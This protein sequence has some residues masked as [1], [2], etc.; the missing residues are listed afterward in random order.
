[1]GLAARQAGPLW[2]ERKLVL[3]LGELTEFQD[4]YP[5]SSCQLFPMQTFKGMRGG[6][7]L[8]L[9]K[10]PSQTVCLVQSDAGREFKGSRVQLR[11]VKVVSISQPGVEVKDI[12]AV[13]PSWSSEKGV[14]RT[15]PSRCRVALGRGGSPEPTPSSPCDKLMPWVSCARGL[16][17]LTL[18]A[19]EVPDRLNLA[20][21]KAVSFT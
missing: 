17:R 7:R 6:S 12:R 2:S 15:E 20:K 4:N 11:Q 18:Q 8:T 16:V 9:W 5:K 21:D 10:P 1:M 13:F 19:E 14:R 3:G